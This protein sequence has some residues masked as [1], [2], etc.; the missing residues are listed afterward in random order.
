[1]GETLSLPSLKAVALASV[2]RDTAEDEGEAVG[3]TGVNALE[4]HCVSECS[5]TLISEP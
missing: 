1:M 3:I 5:L 2:L 4:V